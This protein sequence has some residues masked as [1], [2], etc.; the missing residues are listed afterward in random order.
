VGHDVGRVPPVSSWELLRGCCIQHL[1]TMPH[2]ILRAH[3]GCIAVHA[4]PCILDND[5]DGL[6]PAPS[7]PVSARVLWLGQ[8]VP[9][10]PG[11]WRVPRRKSGRGTA[12]LV[13][14]RQQ[15]HCSAKLLALLPAGI[16]SWRRQRA[17]RPDCGPRWWQRMRCAGHFMGHIKSGLPYK[18]HLGNFPAHPYVCTSPLLLHWSVDWGSTR[19]AS[20]DRLARRASTACSW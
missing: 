12:R 5:V 14:H 16:L 13:R 6:L 1:H 10:L 7:M 18:W 11:G 19:G 2:W 8:S 4:V 9:G 3:V 20:A 17:L 15:Q